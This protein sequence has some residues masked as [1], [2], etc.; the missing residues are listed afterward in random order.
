MKELT[1]RAITEEVERLFLSAGYCIG[2]DVA[3]AIDAGLAREAS[4]A[5]QAALSQIA[6]N[7]RIARERSMPICQDTGMAVVFADLGQDLH[8]IGGSLEEAINE[9]VRRAYTGGYLRKSVVRDPLFDRTNTGDNTPAVIHTRIVPGN[10]L[11]LLVT[12]KGF[13]SENMS[14]IRMLTPAD[15]VAGVKRFI[16]DTIEAAGPNPCPPVIVGVG[17]GGTM[18]KAALLAKRMTARPV[19]S[20]NPNARYQA[21]EEELLEALNRTG[22]GPAGTGGLVTALAVNIDSYPT[23]IAG[24]P[25]AV[26]VCCHAARHAESEMM[27]E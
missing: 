23:H 5:G 11:R 17:I 25:V 7:Y 12:P 27:P 2:V 6:E 16:I 15:G 4:P 8:I 24:L 22:I 14:A 9:G 10:T 18:E 21:L 1:A 19:G 20:K 3:E 13:G 26:N